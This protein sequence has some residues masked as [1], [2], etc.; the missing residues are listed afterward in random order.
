MAC[1][2]SHNAAGS[3][4]RAEQ[5][6]DV[7]LNLL[8]LVALTLPLACSCAA[9]RAATLRASLRRRDHELSKLAMRLSSLCSL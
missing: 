7:H 4:P 6:G 9:C 1:C 3:R 5:D 2:V 8:Q